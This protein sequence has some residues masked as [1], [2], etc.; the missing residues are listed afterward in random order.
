MTSTIVF[1]IR[2]YVSIITEKYDLAERHALTQYFK[3][4]IHGGT[5]LDLRTSNI[6][7]SS[8]LL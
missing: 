3:S 7:I 6:L 1:C 8:T 5:G 2:C 4:T